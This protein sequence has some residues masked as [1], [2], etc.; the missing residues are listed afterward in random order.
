MPD[1]VQA[2]QLLLPLD[3]NGPPQAVDAGSSHASH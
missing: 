1:C 3:S 2:D